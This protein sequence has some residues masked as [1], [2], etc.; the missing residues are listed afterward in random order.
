MSGLVYL[1]GAIGTSI[2]LLLY[3]LH[4]KLLFDKNNEMNDFVVIMGIVV[5]VFWPI[6]LPVLCLSL[7]LTLVLFYVV[8]PPVKRVLL[9]LQKNGF[10]PKIERKPLLT[11]QMADSMLPTF[12]P[13]GNWRS[14]SDD[15]Q[16]PT[17]P[18][19]FRDP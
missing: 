13:P 4:A 12:P 19:I 18:D 6:V 3:T 5:T 8:G 17:L 11:V 7:L 10:H 15:R 14:A 16:L 2:G 1:L 9:H